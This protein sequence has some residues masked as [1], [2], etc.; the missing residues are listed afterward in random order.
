[1]G[2]LAGLIERVEKLDG[3]DREIDLELA[4]A[5]VP[6]VICLRYNWET[7]NNEPFVHWRY[8]ASIDAAI[9]LVER[10]LPGWARGFDAGPKSCIAF[11]D[12]HDY[13]DRMFGARHVATASTPAIALLLALLR[14]MQ[15]EER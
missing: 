3:P 1:M 13:A 9:A 10:C 12:P 15:K 7:S 2:D 11:V 8:T 14:A 6:D 5:L 4:R